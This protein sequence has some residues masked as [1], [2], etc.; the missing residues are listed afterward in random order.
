MRP[1][2]IAASVAAA[3]AVG[4]LALPSSPSRLPEDTA[5]AAVRESSPAP[6]PA[7]LL[8][9]RIERSASPKARADFGT[10]Q[11]KAGVVASTRS[12]P[13]APAP[14]RA[15][16]ETRAA[17]PTMTQ[18]TGLT[19]VQPGQPES[20]A[21]VVVSADPKRQPKAQPN[22]GNPL[23]DRW[24]DD[25]SGPRARLSMGKESSRGCPDCERAPAPKDMS[26]VGVV[27]ESEE[28]IKHPT[29]PLHGDVRQG[30]Y[31]DKTPAVYVD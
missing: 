12:E 13:R 11:R 10:R 28:L 2:V 22:L 31:K 6:L 7:P 8:P 29:A 27:V 5:V 25:L 9:R 20:K 17:E 23:E 3:A 16:P 24:I 15:A 19:P 18:V 1:L 26:L 21:A 30:H 4:Y 14:L